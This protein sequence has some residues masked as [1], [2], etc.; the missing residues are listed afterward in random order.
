MLFFL[1]RGWVGRLGQGPKQPGG[2]LSDGRLEG[3]R[4][5][6]RT[7]TSSAGRPE[8]CSPR[9]FGANLEPAGAGSGGWVLALRNETDFCSTLTWAKGTGKI[10]HCKSIIWIISSVYDRRG[11]LH[12]WTHSVQCQSFGWF[13]LQTVLGGQ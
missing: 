12:R 2:L 9:G 6:R 7:S 5:A 13:L 10:G 1:L 3:D 8:S 4:D 11:G